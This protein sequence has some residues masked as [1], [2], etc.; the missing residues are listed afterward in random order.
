VVSPGDFSY[1]QS[2]PIAAEEVARD[3]RFSLYCFDL[4]KDAALFVETVDPQALVS[5]TFYYQ[6]QVEDAVGLVSMPMA[7][8]HKLAND[9]PPPSELVLVHSVGR[10]GSTLVSKALGAVPSICSLSE[11]D[12]LTQLVLLWVGQK[13]SDTVAPELIASSVRWRGKSLGANQ[14]HLAIKTRS[15]VLVLAPFLA[16]CF[17]D[18][19]HLFLYRN[20]ISW[21]STS[22]RNVPEGHDLYDP[23]TNRAMEERWSRMLPLLQEYR[24]DEVPMNPIQIRVLAWITCMEGYLELRKRGLTVAAA[25]YEDIQASPTAVLDQIFRFCK[26]EDVPWDA[27]EDV[28]GRDS[29]AGTVYARD[30]RYKK[31]RELPPDLIENIRE[32]VATRP[33]LRV[34]DVMLPHTISVD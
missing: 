34:P 25:R 6:A 10:C 27:V 26:V 20:A 23:E 7:T 33:N 2:E 11:P 31:S 19:Q 1:E 3:P 14:T 29:Q 9:I 28:L 22:F 24:R 30:E 32:L 5:A 18:A 15:E 12:D 16:E 4:E 17:P 8:F 13:A 21:M